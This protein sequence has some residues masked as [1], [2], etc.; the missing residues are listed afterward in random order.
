MTKPFSILIGTSA[1]LV[2]AS[3]VVVACSDDELVVGRS[4]LE[5]DAAA[6]SP[7]PSFEDAGPDG[8]KWSGY[9]ERYAFS[10]GS[11]RITLNFTSPTSGTVIFGELPAGPPS[12]DPNAAECDFRIT[13]SPTPPPDRIF[14]AERFELSMSDAL[15]EP[16]RIR[17]AVDVSA[18]YAAWCEGQTLITTI[19][20]WTDGQT[21]HSC[22]GTTPRETST[23][24]AVATQPD[25]GPGILMPEDGG[26]YPRVP[27]ADTFVDCLVEA[28]CGALCTCTATSCRVSAGPVVTFD[29]HIDGQKASGSSPLGNVYLTAQ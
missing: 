8:A 18:K 2:V 7:Q 22:A 13:D 12:V 11:D 24:Q 25:G 29:L 23:C 3:T 5:P 27:A 26:T 6:Q 4:A 15:K 9:I 14:C 21:T 10:S 20:W 16:D 19:G 28:A 1:A 17:F